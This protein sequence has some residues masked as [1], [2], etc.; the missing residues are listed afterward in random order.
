MAAVPP[1]PPVRRKRGAAAPAAKGDDVEDEQ[2]L[3]VSA[4]VLRGEIP[5][6]RAEHWVDARAE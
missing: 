4:G 2:S 6:V 3:L 1:R 5:G